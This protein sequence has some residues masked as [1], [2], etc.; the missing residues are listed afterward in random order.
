VFLGS[1]TCWILLG[2][3]PIWIRVWGGKMV[4]LEV[5]THLSPED[6]NLLIDFILECLKEDW[7]LVE[8]K[9]AIRTTEEELRRSLDHLSR[10][11]NLARAAK[12]NADQMQNIFLLMTKGEGNT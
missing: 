1:E 12:E 8:I 7:F 10:L 5:L 6:R 11:S 9:H 3:C 2:K 4:A